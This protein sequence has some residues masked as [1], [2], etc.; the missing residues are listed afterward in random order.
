M[1][2]S[3]NAERPNAESQEKGGFQLRR[4]EGSRPL[5]D[6]EV[7]VFGNGIVCATD[8]RGH[9]TPGGRSRFDLWLDATEGHIPLWA[10]GVTL[11]WRFQ[12]QS[13]EP[14][15][16]PAGVQSEIR[17]LLGEAV[18]AWGNA[19][20]VKFTE[21]KDNWDFEV[22]IR[23]HDRCSPK[24]C[25]LARA[26]FPDPG[27]HELIIYPKLFSQDSKEQHETLIHEIGHV[28]GL[29]HFFANIDEKEW[30]SVLFG[31]NKRFTIMNYGPNSMLTDD[32]KIDLAQLYQMVWSGQLT[33]INGTRIKLMEPFHSAG[34]SPESVVAV[35]QIQTTIQ[36]VGSMAA[37]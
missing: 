6:S 20:P 22:A 35:G 7:H 10:K 33:E 8:T 11:R 30:P 1:V 29:R 28:F 12:E 31:K 9:D 37:S 18:M 2:K 36:P 23:E 21:R 4:A 24:G 16:D 15:E 32:D 25:V 17:R 19:A 14:F 5:Q 34:A 27:Q 26:F 13:F 3:N